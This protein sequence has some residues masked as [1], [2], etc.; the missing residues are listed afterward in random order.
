MTTV[1]LIGL[2]VWLVLL[3]MVWALCAAAARGDSWL[4]DDGP[5]DHLGP[6]EQP[7]PERAAPII[8][9]FAALRT[10]TDAARLLLRAERVAVV[11][12]DVRDD[13]A[14]GREALAHHDHQRR[15]TVS[16]GAGLVLVAS[17]ASWDPPFE[18]AD[19]RL[20]DAVAQ[21]LRDIVAVADDPP[22]TRRFA[23]SRELHRPL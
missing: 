6:E 22:A 8:V 11:R 10:R 1:V 9:D 4:A 21:S 14:T 16:L 12:P 3:A 17:R 13:P 18:D 5:E 19:R 20:L 7:K 15:I 23:R 2:G